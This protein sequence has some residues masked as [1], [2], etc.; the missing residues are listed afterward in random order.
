[1]I[2][3]GTR[4]LRS[5][6]RVVMLRISVA[7]SRRSPFHRH[8]WNTGTRSVCVM[9]NRCPGRGAG[10]IGF[11]PGMPQSIPIVV[12]RVPLF[13]MSRQIP[14]PG[15]GTHPSRVTVGRRRPKTQFH[16]LDAK[17]P[18][19][20]GHTRWG[21]RTSTRPIGPRAVVEAH[22]AADQ[23]G[24]PD[25]P[26]ILEIL[27]HGGYA[28]DPQHRGRGYAT[29]AIRLLAHVARV[30]ALKRLLV[31]IEPENIPSRRAIE[32]AGFRLLGEADSRQEAVAIGVG[33]RICHYGLE[34]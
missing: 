18:Q 31:H 1:M 15:V 11:P 9:R 7:P 28:V 10:R 32:R 22:Q 3:G 30:R 24:R 12:G 26:T 4:T 19:Q 14:G 5:E 6:R 8:R 16:R 2:P 33:P 17:R 25:D 21:D 13:H 29:R 27:G 23:V 34:L 20:P